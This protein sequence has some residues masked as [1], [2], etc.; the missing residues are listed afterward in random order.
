MRVDVRKLEVAI[1]E[2][3]YRLAFD[4]DLDYPR[5]YRDMDQVFRPTLSEF[6]NGATED[7]QADVGVWHEDQFIALISFV[8]IV[9]RRLE[10][11]LWA[12]R[13]ACT[14]A[15]AWAAFNAMHGLFQ[16]GAKEVTAWLSSKN[17]PVKKMCIMTGMK[18]DGLRTWRKG[19][20]GIPLQWDRYSAQHG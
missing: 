19:P 5:W 10:I 15:I 14:E 3:L 11:N 20:R 7:N 6:L 12:K 1:D 4:W 2:D 18:R 16:N 8:E 9:P 17:V 13:K